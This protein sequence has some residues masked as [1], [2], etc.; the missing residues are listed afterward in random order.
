MFSNGQINVLTI[1]SD[2]PGGFS[3]DQLGYLYEILPNLGRLLEAHVQRNSTLTLLQTY[4]GR[5]AGQRV[6]GGLIQRGDGEELHAVIWFSDLRESTKLAETLSRQEY[7]AVLNQYFDGVAGAVIHEG[8]EVLKFI[9]DA[10]LAIFPIDDPQDSKPDACA[11]AL[12]AV[13]RAHENTKLVNQ[14][15][16]EA[17]Q[18]PL[19]FGIGLHRGTITYGNVGTEGRLDFTVIGPAVNETARIEDLCKTLDEP[20]LMSS[21]FA[22]GAPGLLVSLG[23]HLL[24]GVQGP[25]EIYTIANS[26]KEALSDR[27][28]VG[29]V[30]GNYAD[31]P[32]LPSSVK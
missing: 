26:Q 2:A 15:R 7:L 30:R 1:V 27:P 25:R 12:A 31:R 13:R 9:G 17:G 4:L 5:N 24:R 8:G 11:R 22:K 20:I 3:T 32:S 29:S 10:V 19:K 21:V 28:Q 16:Q 23:D 14:Q 6:D 18:D